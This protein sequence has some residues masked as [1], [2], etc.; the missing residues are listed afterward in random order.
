MNGGDRAGAG[1]AWLGCAANFNRRGHEAGVGAAA[2]C[3]RWLD[4]LVIC[5][6]LWLP[7]GSRRSYSL[8][9]GMLWEEDDALALGNLEGV[10]D[11]LAL[12]NLGGVGD[13]VD[14]YI[15]RGSALTFT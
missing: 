14:G 7:A 8:A 12:G 2:S 13:F 9:L 3:R 5:W 15:W 4:R 10:D 1:C 11:T 6:G